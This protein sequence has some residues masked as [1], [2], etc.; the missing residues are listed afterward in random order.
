M[1]A[2]GVVVGGALPTLLV[3]VRELAGH[4][5]PAGAGLLVHHLGLTDLV[6]LSSAAAGPIAVDVDTVDG[7]APDEAA[8][9]FLRRRLGV[10]I[11]ITRRPPLAARALEYGLTSLLHVHCLDSTGLE[12][13]MA[14]HPGHPVGTAVSPGPILAHLSPIQ[15]ERLP[16]PVLAYGLIDGAGP[17]DAALAAG[18]D[19]VVV[20]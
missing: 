11:V 5:A 7:L 16:R 13:A 4:P 14:A 1:A 15:R 17:R 3:S 9:A 6:R 19:S 18:A 2:R 12:H 8:I 20:S 10:A